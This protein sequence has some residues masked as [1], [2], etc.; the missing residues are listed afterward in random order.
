VYETPDDLAAL[1]ALLDESYAA[2]GAHLRSIQTPERRVH[3][4]DLVD[5]LRGVRVLDLATVN[6]KCEPRVGPV[7]GLFYRGQFY[8]GSAHESVRFRHIR[9]RPQVSGAHVI[10]ETFSVIVHGTAAELDV[11]QP[12]HAA[13]KAYVL[14]VYPDWESWYQ[15][16]PPPYARIDAHRMY[17]YAFEPSVLDELRS[18]T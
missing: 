4:A 16:P 14:E 7:D 5:I 15:G 18:G 9:A 12:E 10:G 6:V 1:Q 3:A 2:A 13:F 8:F 17:A 11:S